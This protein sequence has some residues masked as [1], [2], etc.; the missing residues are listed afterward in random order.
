[1]NYS[2]I[3]ELQAT[4]A[5]AALSEVPH[6]LFTLEFFDICGDPHGPRGLTTETSGLKTSRMWA[7]GLMGFIEYEVDDGAKVVTITNVISTV[8]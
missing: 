7:V 3:I 8:G 2:L 5:L 6:E 4:K 1:M